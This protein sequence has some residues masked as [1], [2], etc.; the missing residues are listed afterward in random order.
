MACPQYQKPCLPPTAFVFML[1][2]RLPLPFGGQRAA[3]HTLDEERPDRA[4]S[5]IATPPP[6]ERRPC[7]VP[8]QRRRIRRHPPSAS[9]RP[10]GS[11]AAPPSASAW[12]WPPCSPAPSSSTAPSG[13]S[14]SMWDRARHLVVTS[15]RQVSRVRMYE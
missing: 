7:L 2:I 6:T 11:T 3:N 12:C 15:G 1:L 8:A 9:A 13:W 14:P 4:S 10:P 5:A